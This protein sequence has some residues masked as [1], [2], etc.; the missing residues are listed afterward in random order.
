MP[1]SAS[2]VVKVSI[3]SVCGL[4]A[5]VGLFPALLRCVLFGTA[6]WHCL[7]HPPSDRGV[8]RTLGKGRYASR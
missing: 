7:G 8:L 2:Q 1:C 3:E 5:S 4:I 6:A